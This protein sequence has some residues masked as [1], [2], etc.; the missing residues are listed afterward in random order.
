MRIPIPAI[1]VPLVVLLLYLFV[2]GLNYRGAEDLHLDRGYYQRK[3]AR[4]GKPAEAKRKTVQPLT[5]TR[6]GPAAGDSE[7]PGKEQVASAL[8]RNLWPV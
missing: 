2:P 1:V 8:A 3:F 5:R 7:I 4:R 6:L